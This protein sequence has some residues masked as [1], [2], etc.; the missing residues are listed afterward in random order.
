MLNVMILSGLVGAVLGTRLKVLSLVPA[1]AFAFALIAGVGIVR[2]DG[3]W[4]ILTTTVLSV[5]LLQCGYLGGTASRL[6]VAAT[7]VSRGHALAGARPGS[8]QRGRRAINP[9]TR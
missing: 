1:M 8:A 3:L 5:V 7:R 6:V 2:G 4:P 9:E